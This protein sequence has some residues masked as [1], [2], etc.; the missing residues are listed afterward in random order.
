MPSSNDSIPNEL[1]LNRF[2]PRN[3][4]PAPQQIRCCCSQSNSQAEAQPVPYCQSSQF[5]QRTDQIDDCETDQCLNRCRALGFQQK[6]RHRSRIDPQASCANRNRNGENSETA[7][8]ILMTHAREE[9]P[10]AHGCKW[11]IEMKQHGCG[12]GCDGQH[13]CETCE[14]EI[15]T[16]KYRRSHK[17]RR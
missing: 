5:C 12:H 9:E 1:T 13:P 4:R 11:E 16:S 2:Y 10:Q 15:L 14:L 3:P 6:A 8:C 17:L 7:V